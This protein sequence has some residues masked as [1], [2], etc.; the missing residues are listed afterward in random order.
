MTIS[1]RNVLRS[2]A[3][4][5]AGGAISVGLRKAADE[6]PLDVPDSMRSLGQPVLSSPYGVP[7]KFEKDV[8]RRLREPV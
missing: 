3:T 1:R 4:I 8:V 2:S 7:S 6:A 5:V